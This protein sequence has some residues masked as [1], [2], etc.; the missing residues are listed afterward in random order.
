MLNINYLLSR[1]ESVEVCF[2]S[3]HMPLSH[4]EGHSLRLNNFGKIVFIVS[5]RLMSSLLCVFSLLTSFLIL[6]LVLL[7]FFVFFFSLYVLF[8]YLHSLHSDFSSLLVFTH[9]S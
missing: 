1:L 9:K 6:S 8:P 5:S 3:P 2:C 7:P 4:A